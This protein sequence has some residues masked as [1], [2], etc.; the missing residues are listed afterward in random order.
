MENQNGFQLKKLRVCGRSHVNV[1]ICQA[2]RIKGAVTL[3]TQGSLLPVLTPLL[4]QG[5]V[6]PAGQLVYIY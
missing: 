6:Q 5:R 4:L 3:A 2:E 1:L